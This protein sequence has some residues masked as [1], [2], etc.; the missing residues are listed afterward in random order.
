MVKSDII[1]KLC[2]LYPNLYRND[3]TKVVDIF[4]DEISNSLKEGNNCE[5]RSFGTFKAK[6]R[7]AREA[8]NPKSGQKIF[9]QQKRIP[10]FKMSR[11][12]RIEINKD[13]KEEEK[14]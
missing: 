3:L 11:L 8:R 9:V 7:K 4:F 13:L 12:L 1:Q 2:N 6:T 10:A 5:I 14:L